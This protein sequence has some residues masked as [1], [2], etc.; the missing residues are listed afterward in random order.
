MRWQRLVIWGGLSLAL[1]AGLVYSFWPRPLPVDLALVSRGPMRVTID[2]EGETR[3][4]DI[5]TVSAPISGRALRIEAEA[6]DAVVGGETVLA[7]IEPI[8]P[9]FLDVRSRA[10]A[11]AEAK[12]AEAA[13]AL[14]AAERTRAAAE[15]DFARAELARARKLFPRGNISESKFDAAKLA[16]RTMQAALAEAEAALQVRSFEA[17]MARARLIEPFLD[18]FAPAAPSRC[19]VPVL[20]PVSGRVLRVLHESAGVVAAGTPLV[21]VGDSA[22][23]EIVADFLSSDAVKLAPGAAVLIEDWGG[24]AA[25]AGKLRRVEPYGFTKVSALGIEEQRVDVVIDLTG[26]ADK[27][28]ALGHGYRV[29]VRVVVWQADD[30]LRL[31]LGALFRHGGDWAVFLAEEGRA[32][33]RPVV[34][35]QRNEHEA[36]I[37][38]GLR[39]DDRVVLHPSDRIENGV[40]IAPRVA[41]G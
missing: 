20:A 9:A 29:E 11:E 36:E 39:P 30:V 33:L 40:R 7:Q 27:W 23:L 5:Y 18:G 12:A 19:C 32:V 22:A 14:A 38:E 10:A 37:L 28:Q 17:E 3:V 13:L 34:V 35:G 8:D 31:P 26:P 6:G 2:D 25:L 1:A 24:G 16:E 21:E 15:L 4:K 41:A